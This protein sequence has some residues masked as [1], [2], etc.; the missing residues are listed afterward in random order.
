VKA[1]TWSAIATW[2]PIVISIVSLAISI[3]FGVIRPSRQAKAANPTAQLDLLN[4]ETKSVSRQ[5]VRVVV[6]NSGPSTMENVTVEVFDGDGQ[7]LAEAEPGDIT[8]LWPKMPVSYLHT[9]Q[10][11]YLTLNLSYGSRDP[12]A[13]VIRWRDGRDG[14]QSRRFELSYNRVAEQV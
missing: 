6:T 1:L 5:E 8:D 14:E 12:K 10:S 11:L 13:A 9:G 4:Y 3:W 2:L 7:D